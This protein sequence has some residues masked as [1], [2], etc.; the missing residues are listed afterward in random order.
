[1]K[2]LAMIGTPKDY[3][4]E[5]HYLWLTE[6]CN[7]INYHIS[8]KKNNNSDVI[9]YGAGTT[10]CQPIKFWALLFHPWKKIFYPLLSLVRGR[11]GFDVGYKARGACRGAENLVNLS[12]NKY[13]RQRQYL[14]FSRLSR[15]TSA[16]S[17]ACAFS[18]GSTLHKL[19]EEF[20]LG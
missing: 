14:R 13:S 6:C 16:C 17:C 10:K 2:F 7:Q 12:A 3:L 20:C 19:A 4:L 8:F 1:M 9:R 18:Q 15:L 11:H 5:T